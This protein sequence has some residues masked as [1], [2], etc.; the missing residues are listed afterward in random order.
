MEVTP[1]PN[2]RVERHTIPPHARIPN[3]PATGGKPLLIYRSAFGP[4]SAVTA[5]AV[6]AHLRAVGVVEPS[7]RYGMFGEVHFHS[8]THEVLVVV[9]GRA[10]LEFGGEGNPGGVE[11]VVGR[12]D[13]VVVPAGV[14]HRLVQEEE[15]DGEKFEMVGSY[16]VGAKRWDMCY[17][18]EGEEG[19]VDGI[20]GLGWFGGDPV[21]G[22]GG[23]GT[24]V[25]GLRGRSRDGRT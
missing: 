24:C 15:G 10:R 9:R 19:R 3:S 22:G 14:G 12:G 1:F 20:R 8:T 18:R 2:L 13:V 6:E 7:W 5:P 4:A 17:G 16:P 21:Y 11:A 23:G 25:G